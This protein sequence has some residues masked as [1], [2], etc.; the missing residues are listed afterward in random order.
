MHIIDYVNDLQKVLSQGDDFV[1]VAVFRFFYSPYRRHGRRL[2]EYEGDA[3]PT[4]QR[5]WESTRNVPFTFSV[6]KKYV[7]VHSVTVHCPFLKDKQ[8]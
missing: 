2:V 4:F 8:S 7:Q 6:K 5:V 1:T 3:S